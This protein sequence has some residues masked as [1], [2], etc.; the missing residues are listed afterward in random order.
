MSDYFDGKWPGEE[1]ESVGGAMG[2]E[3][4]EPVCDK[5]GDARVAGDLY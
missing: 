1:Y 4:V 5:L 2:C 3:K